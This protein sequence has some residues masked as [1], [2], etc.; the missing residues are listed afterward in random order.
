MG[1][2]AHR[3][4]IEATAI[5]LVEPQYFDDAKKKA[6]G[7]GK[8]NRKGKRHQEARKTIR[9]DL[10]D[11]GTFNDG[12]KTE[13]EGDSDSDEGAVDDAGDNDLAG[14]N[15]AGI[16]GSSIHVS[17]TATAIE[18]RDGLCVGTKESNLHQLLPT[19]AGLS[20]V[21][22]ES[23]AMD[24]FINARMRGHCRQL[25][26]DQYFGNNGDKTYFE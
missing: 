21:E 14:T 22:Y 11:A 3:D 24:A 26:T 19:A 7:L 8:R 20:K 4:G 12:G 6:M 9:T 16:G 15:G 25:L 5:Y 13:T 18:T 17:K 2:G 1:R 23:I 10:Q